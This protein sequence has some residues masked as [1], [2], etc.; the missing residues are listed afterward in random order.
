M[1]LCTF[2]VSALYY[3]SC[4]MDLQLYYRSCPM[5]LQLYYRSCPMDLQFPIKAVTINQSM[6]GGGAELR[7]VL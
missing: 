4:P 5:D 1:L 7:A 3:R 6:R 2:L